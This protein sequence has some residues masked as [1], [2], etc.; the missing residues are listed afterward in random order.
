MRWQTS[1]DWPSA[2]VNR[3]RV[4][5]GG[6]RL[7]VADI[8]NAAIAMNLRPSRASRPAVYDQRVG[9]QRRVLNAGF[10]FLTCRGDF[11]LVGQPL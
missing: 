1:V 2:V 4:R 5:R 7:V 6:R 11:F 9:V 8:I 10:T 3:A